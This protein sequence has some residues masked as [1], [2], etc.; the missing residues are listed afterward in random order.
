MNLKLQYE[1]KKETQNCHTSLHDKKRKKRTLIFRLH[2][3]IGNNR[4]TAC[5][6]IRD[7]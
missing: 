2:P 7:I 6:Q 5:A 3:N 1:F 4:I